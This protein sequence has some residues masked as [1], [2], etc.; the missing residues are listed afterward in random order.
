MRPVRICSLLAILTSD[1]LL[2]PSVS[3][4]KIRLSPF[5]FLGPW[6]VGKNEVDADPSFALHPDGVFGLWRDER[7]ERG[8][9]IQNSTSARRVFF[10]EL[11]TGGSRHGVEDHDNRNSLFVLDDSQLHSKSRN[12]NGDRVSW[13]PR[14]VNWQQLVNDLSAL[15]VQEWQGWAVAEGMVKVS[16][17]DFSV[18]QNFF[19]LSIQCEGVRAF[20]VDSL[21]AFPFSGDLFWGSHGKMRNLV[22]IDKTR[23]V[24]VASSSSSSAE[25]S[26]NREK[27]RKAKFSLFVALKTKGPGHDFRCT[28]DAKMAVELNVSP[29][30]KPDLLELGRRQKAGVTKSKAGGRQKKYSLMGQ[31]VGVEVSNNSPEWVRVEFLPTASFVRAGFE[32]LSLTAIGRA[33]DALAVPTTVSGRSDEE[34][35]DHPLLGRGMRTADAAG[36]STPALRAYDRLERL[37]VAPGQLTAVPLRIGV[38]N[39][40]MECN[41]G[42]KRKDLRVKAKVF[43]WSHGTGLIIM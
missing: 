26:E 2:I 31:Y 43:G 9:V 33:D 7:A 5:R 25:T 3:A 40:T 34:D 20:W 18:G 13:V 30:H 29:Q 24:E 11:L 32:V 15:E 12:V 39:D 10:S 19:P 42:S 23:F 28:V 17:E 22:R 36:T 14:D 27:V 8:H 1:H 38:V 4:A 37:T 6:P 41:D 35:I 21:E 16:E